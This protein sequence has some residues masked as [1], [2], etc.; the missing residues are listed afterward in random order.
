MKAYDIEG[1]LAKVSVVFTYRGVDISMSCIAHPAEML[2]Y[3]AGTGED[4]TQR[5][6]GMHALSASAQAFIAVIQA[7]DTF[8]DGEDEQKLCS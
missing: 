6:I 5:I 2:L 1:Q 4:L 3:R 8:M 7:I